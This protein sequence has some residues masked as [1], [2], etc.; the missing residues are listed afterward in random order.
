MIG[1]DIV[2]ID[3]IK[4]VLLKNKDAFL[5]KVLSEKEFEEICQIQSDS[6]KIKFLSKRFATKEAYIKAIGG[7]YKGLLMKNIT[8]THNK[9]GQPFISVNGEILKKCS[10]SISDEEDYAVAV[11]LIL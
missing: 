3:R 1:I 4:S 7:Y 8:V 10:V 11:V 2:K 6:L 9:A 5:K